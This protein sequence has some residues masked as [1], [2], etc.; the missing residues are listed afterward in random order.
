MEWKTVE[1]I[2]NRGNLSRLIRCMERAQAGEKLTIGFTGGSITQGSLSSSP[3]TCYAYLV[4]KWWQ[5]SFPETEFVYVNGGIGGTTSQFGVARV[6]DDLLVYKPDFVI[7]D[8]SVNDENTEHFKETYEG[9]IRNIYKEKHMPAVLPVCNVRYDD[10]TNAQDMHLAIGKA[11][12]LPVISM[13][14]AVYSKVASGEIAARTITPDDLHPNDKGHKL[15]AG[16]ITG[17][18]DAVREQYEKGMIQRTEEEPAMPAPITENGYEHSV[19][20]RSSNYHADCEGFIPDRQKSLENPPLFTQGWTASEAG[21]RIT[22]RIKAAAIAVQYRKSVRT[23]VPAVRVVIDGD[24][25]NAKIL[26]ADFNGGWG[27]C[28]CIDTIAEHMEDTEHRVELV[29]METG[30]RAA[31]PFYLASVIGSRQA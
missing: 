31:V 11:Y 5:A 18:L 10:G 29:V 2:I 15:V 12:N 26:D 14:Q 28:L 30:E 22:F 8:F 4:Y 20:Y 27:D 19:R 1:G 6:Q 17:F 9:L 7:V 3:Q 25:E 23:P 16:V 21:E 13:K 24:I